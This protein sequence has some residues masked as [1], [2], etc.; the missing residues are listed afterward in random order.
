MRYLNPGWV[1]TTAGC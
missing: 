1:I